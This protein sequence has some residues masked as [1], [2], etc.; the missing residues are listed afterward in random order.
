MSR[1]GGGVGLCDL[2]SGSRN[3]RSFMAPPSTDSSLASGVKRRLLRA[4]M[5][6]IRVQPQI[7][8]V[9]TPLVPGLRFLRCPRYVLEQPDHGGAGNTEADTSGLSG[10][11]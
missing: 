6:I 11:L 8:F 9:S 3:L 2:A 7:V 5:Q 4:F 1:G 10:D